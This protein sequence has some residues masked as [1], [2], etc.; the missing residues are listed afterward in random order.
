MAGDLDNCP[1][2]G[3]QL[4]F[5]EVDIGVGVLKGNARCEECG[6]EPELP[7]DKLTLDSDVGDEGDDA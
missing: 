1:S 3:A 5:D 6:W 2:C 4:T 7:E